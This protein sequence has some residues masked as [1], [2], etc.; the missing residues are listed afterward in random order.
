MLH[1][2]YDPSWS[3]LTPPTSSPSRPPPS[4]RILLFTDPSGRNGASSRG[5]RQPKQRRLVFDSKSV[6]R[7][8]GIATA[9]GKDKYDEVVGGVG[10]K[11]GKAGTN[12]RCVWY[13][14]SKF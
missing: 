7:D 5:T 6:R 3:A 8:E 1:Q 11:V 9:D 12:S 2:L 14:Y 4:V 13:W 10:Y